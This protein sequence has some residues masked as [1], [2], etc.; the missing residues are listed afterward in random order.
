MS[1][2]AL[3]LRGGLVAAGLAVLAVGCVSTGI[4]LV[5][6]GEEGHASVGQ[7]LIVVSQLASADE[8]W[9]AAFEKALDFELKRSGSPFLIQSRNPLALQADK[10]RYAAQ[11]REFNPDLVLVVEPGDG[12]VD[13]RGRSYK[14]RFEAGVFRNYA[15]RSKRELAWR[16]SIDLDPAGAFIKAE[17]MPALARDLVA[18]LQSDGMLPKQKR[19]ISKAPVK[20]E[21]SLLPPV[22]TTRGYGR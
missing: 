7:S 20:V 14:R 18:K 12:T 17:D 16:G 10:A 6:K 3:F 13:T 1:K 11:I 2:H 21:E 8:A 15:E 19:N 4:Q 9:A 22:R 5:S